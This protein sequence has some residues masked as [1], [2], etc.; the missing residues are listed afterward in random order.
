MS[1][2]D[3][4]EMITIPEGCI[5]I[6]SHEGLVL[7]EPLRPGQHHTHM[8]VHVMPLKR[9]LPLK[10]DGGIRVSIEYRLAPNQVPGLF[11]DSQ[12]L[13]VD[14]S[15]LEHSADALWSAVIEEHLFQATSLLPPMR[16]LFASRS[17]LFAG[18]DA[19]DEG[20]QQSLVERASIDV[21]GALHERWP[22]LFEWVQYSIS[23][24][25]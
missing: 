19:L 23:L 12:G 20:E 6:Q 17:G 5:G 24:K 13:P 18:F 25:K 8:T 22:G 9:Q 7:P 3:D 14:L 11:T 21:M 16:R 1:Q 4:P 15:R 10:I 2:I